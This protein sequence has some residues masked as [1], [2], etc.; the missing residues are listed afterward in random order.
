MSSPMPSKFGPEVLVIF[1]GHSNDADEEA[2]AIRNLE[3]EL[4]RVHRDFVGLG[5]SVTPMLNEP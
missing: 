1:I 5:M 2:Q 3:R 4:G